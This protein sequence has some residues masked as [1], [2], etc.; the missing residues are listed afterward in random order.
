[1]ETTLKIALNLVVSDHGNFLLRKSFIN[2][3]PS[4]K[5]NEYIVEIKRV[6]AKFLKVFSSLK[7]KKK[8]KAVPS[9]TQNNIIMPLRFMICYLGSKI[10]DIKSI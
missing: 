9:D 3:F 5:T 4:P 6:I 2:A 8:N 10:L 1:M 7:T